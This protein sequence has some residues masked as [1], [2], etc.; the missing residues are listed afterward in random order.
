MPIFDG[1]KPGRRPLAAALV[2][3]ALVAAL[4]VGC[5]AGQ[6]ATIASPLTAQTLSQTAKRS[7]NESSARFSFSMNMSAPGLGEDLGFTG[8]GAFDAAAERASLR[9]DMSAFAA[10]IGAGLG[11]LGGDATAD[12]GDPEAWKI[13]LLQDGEVVYLRFPLLADQLP[14]GKSWVRVDVR[15]A[16]GLQGFD[17]G[18]LEQLGSNDP[19]ELLKLLEAVAGELETVGGEEVRGAETTH[20]RGTIDLRRYAQLFPPDKREEAASMLDSI[21]A[22]A[23]LDAMPVDVWIDDDQRVRKVELSLSAAAPGT[24]ESFDATV[25][26][27]M[28]DYGVA[29]D[30]DLPSPSDVVDASALVPAAG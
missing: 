10:V 27:E 23:G 8:E 25:T 26:I 18:Q 3:A 9:F 22:Q 17:L 28:Y 13:E 19:R 5:G 1:V 16:A 29:V 12:F 15:K 24:S 11:A 30:L 2:L 6:E 7:A 20:Y 14:E 21:V 4:A